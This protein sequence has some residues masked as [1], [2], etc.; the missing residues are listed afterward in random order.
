[1]GKNEHPPAFWALFQESVKGK[2]V[3]NGKYRNKKKIF[4][5]NKF[6]IRVI[7]KTIYDSEARQN[8]NQ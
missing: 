7:K 6:L 1:M 8:K 4:I 5:K 3:V 2:N